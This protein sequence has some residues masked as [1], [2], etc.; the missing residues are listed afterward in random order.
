MPITVNCQCGHQFRVRDEYAGKKAQ[1]PNCGEPV[2]IP[3]ASAQPASLGESPGEFPELQA[4][5]TF[6]SARGPRSNGGRWF[7]GLDSGLFGLGRLSGL[8]LLLIGLVF[9]LLARGCDSLANR[10]TFAK[11]ARYR[12]ELSEFNDE[13][14]DKRSELEEKIEKL[15]KERAEIVDV[16]ES[17]EIQKRLRDAQ[18]EL[19]EHNED[20]QQARRNKERG[21]WK[22]LKRA[23]ENAMN[24]NILGQFWRELL[25]VVGTV[26]LSVGLLTVGFTGEPHERKICL[27]MITIITFSIY[28]GGI[29][30]FET[31]IA[32]AA[33][34]TGAG[35]FR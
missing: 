2:V 10:S 27:I 22:S 25:F 14:E 21:E 34:M 19:S 31:L 23:S 4:A 11:S 8:A 30:W 6:P 12:L 1:C 15:Q 26:I 29:A 3:Q 17:E 20:H 13:W 35:S 18:E 32:R 24:N 16:T 7:A 5:S 28:V 9:V 33:S